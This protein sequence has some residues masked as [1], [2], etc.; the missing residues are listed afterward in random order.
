MA[1]R[2]SYTNKLACCLVDNRTKSALVIRGI[3]VLSHLV[4]NWGRTETGEFYL[5]SRYRHLLID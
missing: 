1:G 2:G 3:V 4:S 5:F